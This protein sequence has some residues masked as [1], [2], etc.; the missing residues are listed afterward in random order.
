MV[1][2]LFIRYHCQPS[3]PTLAKTFVPKPEIAIHLTVQ[4]NNVMQ[5]MHKRLKITVRK[6]YSAAEQ[7]MRFKTTWIPITSAKEPVSSCTYKFQCCL[8]TH[9][10]RDRQLSVCGRRHSGMAATQ[11]KRKHMK[12]LHSRQAIK[13]W[14]RPYPALFLIWAMRSAKIGPLE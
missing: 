12:I 13:I 6:A 3:R 8:A 5:H 2:Q 14:H 9:I 1:I 11:I 10:C 7:N 4:G